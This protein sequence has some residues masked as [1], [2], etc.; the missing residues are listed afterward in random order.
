M[1]RGSRVNF[2]ALAL[3]ILDD[4]ETLLKDS[5]K[6][7]NFAVAVM[8]SATRD[9]DLIRALVMNDFDIEP[10]HKGSL[11]KL[12]YRSCVRKSHGMSVT[13]EP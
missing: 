12:N 2:V 9:S 6:R 3:P 10:K 11:V 13:L 5:D 4:E 7:S 8:T 1:F